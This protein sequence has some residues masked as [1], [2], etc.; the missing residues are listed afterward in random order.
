MQHN[1]THVRYLSPG[2]AVSIER[3]EFPRSRHLTEQG[4]ID[5]GRA[6]A[7]ETH[8]ELVIHAANGSV[9]QRINYGAHAL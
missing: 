4:A 9:R 3:E 2:W 6:L 1:T 5:A 7:Q 8:G